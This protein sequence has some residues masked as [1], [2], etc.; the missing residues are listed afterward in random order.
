MMARIKDNILI[1]AVDILG[2]KLDAFSSLVSENVLDDIQMLRIC[3]LY[4]TLDLEATQRERDHAVDFIERYTATR[5]GGVDEVSE[6]DEE[7]D[8]EQA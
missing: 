8:L 3:A 1:A 4:Q 7:G 5:N 6:K 2:K